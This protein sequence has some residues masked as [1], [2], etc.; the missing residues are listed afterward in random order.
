M[1]FTLDILTNKDNRSIMIVGKGMVFL[2]T[3]KNGGIAMKNLILIEII[4]E[5]Y[6]R[7]ASMNIN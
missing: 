5:K 1:N 6:E 2:F 3:T 7:Y 4:R